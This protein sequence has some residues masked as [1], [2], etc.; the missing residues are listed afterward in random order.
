MN[1]QTLVKIK[2]L[3]FCY[4]NKYKLMIDD[5]DIPK[6]K[7]ITILGQSGSGKTTLL[8][9]IAGFLDNKG[10]I[11]TSL[12]SNSIGYIMQKNN[13]YEQITVLKN[14]W[15]SAKNSIRW[16]LNTYKKIF[17]ILNLNNL[18]K[19]ID[20]LIDLNKQKNIKRSKWIKL[21]F[22]MFFYF[23]KKPK[24]LFLFFKNQ[25][26]IFNTE[27]DKLLKILDIFE[28]KNN[29]AFNI[30]GG[31]EQRVAFAKAII[32]GSEFILM[33][34]PFA[35][36]DAKIKQVAIKW[37]EEIKN[38]FNLSIILV[39]HDQIDALKIS[40]LIILL[41][42]GKLLQYSTPYELFEN[43]NNLYVAKF[44]GFPEI[45]YLEQQN[46]K[47]LY[48]RSKYI[49]VEDVAN[50]AKLIDKKNIGDS[51]LL[52][53]LDTEK[54]INIEIIT[55]KDIKNKDISISYQKDKILYFDNQG[56][57]INYEN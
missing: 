31:Q 29:K 1:N 34:E 33:D 49:D 26:K 4:D 38:K 55:T 7:I 9:L 43:P 8:N 22:I 39:T 15:I 48:I 13:L 3:N 57:R 50:N 56:N 27:V 54:N 24:N 41:K 28:I 6:N 46:D 51:F 18:V 36:L 42:D 23:I 32:K 52:K 14:I 30:S 12:D 21:I 37:L 11:K 53:V 16:K 45:N 5:L 25:K 47:F 2:N 44:I 10:S 35:S 19:Y 20:E 17:S 40:D